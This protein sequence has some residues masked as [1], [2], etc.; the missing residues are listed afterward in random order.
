MKLFRE[1]TEKV[2]EKLTDPDVTSDEE[3]P[4]ACEFQWGRERLTSGSPPCC[5]FK[6]TA[7]ALHPKTLKQLFL[8]LNRRVA[9]H[10]PRQAAACSSTC[11]RRGAGRGPAGGGRAL[12]RDAVLRV[13]VPALAAPPEEL[14]VPQQHRPAHQ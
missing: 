7:P 3:S 5:P 10:S 13:P 6:Q 11:V 8:S 1:R 2:K 12:L 14:P 4:A 9:S